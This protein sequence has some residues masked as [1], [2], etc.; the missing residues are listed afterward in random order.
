M[1]RRFLRWGPN[2]RRCS[3]CSRGCVSGFSEKPKEKGLPSKARWAPYS[4]PFRKVIGPRFTCRAHSAW[5]SRWKDLEGRSPC[6]KTAAR[7]PPLRLRRGEVLFQ[8]KERFAPKKTRG[9]VFP[10]QQEVDPSSIYTLQPSFCLSS[11]LHPRLSPS[12]TR[13]RDHP[14]V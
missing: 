6:R 12:K 11:P 1:R 8:G 9:C 3:S 13:P 2:D 14:R 5:Y 7:D 4:G 10:Q